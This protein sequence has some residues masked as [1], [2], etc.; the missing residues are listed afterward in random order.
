MEP[1]RG[2][3]R[4]VPIS[5]IHRGAT[6]SMVAAALCLTLAGCQGVSG[7]GASLAS[8]PN[9][10]CQQ[11]RADFAA[12]KNYFQDKIVTGAAIGAAIV[13]AGWRM[14]R[15]R[16]R[17]RSIG[18]SSKQASTPASA[19]KASRLSTARGSTGCV[20]LIGAP[21]GRRASIVRFGFALDRTCVTFG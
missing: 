10:P 5:R 13:G 15:T 16:S 12:S 14:G 20:S 19:Q 1:L 3:M 21:Y 8:D 9:D 4:N 18:A 11:Q 6:A 2:P 17:V 7:P